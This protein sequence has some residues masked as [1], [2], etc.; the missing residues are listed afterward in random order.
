MYDAKKEK[1]YETSLQIPYDPTL[2][3]AEMRNPM[4]DRTNIWRAVVWDSTDKVAYGVTGGG[5]I[6]FKFDPHD[7]PEGKITTLTKMC[8]SKFLDGDHKD[9]PYSTLAFAVD[10][11]NRKVY[12]APS[13]RNYNTKGYD[14]T[15]GSGEDHH[16]IMYDIKTNQRVDLG[17]MRTADGRKVFGCEAASFAPNGILYICG[18]VEV[19]DKKTATGMIGDIPVALQLII[20]KP[21]Q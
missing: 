18:Q 20:Y 2:F 7:G 21:Q 12:F 5:S 15:F 3:P 10:N 4:I 11:R 9:I 1:V 16:L 14:E 17:A 6:L 19:K 13:A 8:D